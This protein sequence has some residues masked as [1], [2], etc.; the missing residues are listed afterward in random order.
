VLDRR[1]DDL[2]KSF[3]TPLT[4]KQR[5][6]LVAA[7]GDVER[8]LTAALVEIRPTDPTSPTPRRA[9]V[10]TSRSWIAGPTRA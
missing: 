8:L 10:V 2:A 7:M 9:F 3:L 4:R 1:S 6:R 5:G